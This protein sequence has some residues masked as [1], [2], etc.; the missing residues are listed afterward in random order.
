MLFARKSGPF[1]H[2]AG[3]ID[4]CDRLEALMKDQAVWSQATFGTDEERGPEGPLKHLSK[5]ALEAAEKPKDIVEQADCFL[6][7]LDAI[8]RAGFTLEQ[9]II[10]AEQKMVINKERTWP[11]PTSPTEPVFHV[12]AP[13]E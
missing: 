5:E 10:A 6:L 9:V 12:K 13:H 8:R 4:F 7:Q 2:S 3:A 1:S 11:K